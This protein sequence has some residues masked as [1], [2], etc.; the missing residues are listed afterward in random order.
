MREMGDNRI[1]A[2]RKERI[3]VTQQEQT[4]TT[5][6]AWELGRRF[7]LELI[8]DD[9]K[10][11]IEKRRRGKLQTKQ[12]KRAAH[13]SCRRFNQETAGSKACSTHASGKAEVK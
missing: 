12:S 9:R 3:E 13:D 1:K 11:R 6:V 8:L 10:V 2:N 5:P 7:K 4:R